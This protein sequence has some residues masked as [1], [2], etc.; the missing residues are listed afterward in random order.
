MRVSSTASKP[1]ASP[2]LPYLNGGAWATSQRGHD[3]RLSPATLVLHSKGSEMTSRRLKIMHHQ[4][5]LVSYV[6]NWRLRMN[7]MNQILNVQPPV[8]I[9]QALV[10]LGDNTR[11]L[12]VMLS[13]LDGKLTILEE[14]P[15]IAGQEIDYQAYSDA[16]TFLKMCYLLVRILF[17][18]VAGIIKYFYDENEPNSG[19]TISFN[20]LLRNAEKGRLPK[21]L[22]T[23]L[24]RTIVQF[25]IMRGR[26]D[27][28]E[29]Y[30]ESLLISFGQ[31]ED[32]KTTVGHFSTKRRTAKQ[33]E[34]IRQS[35]GSIL[36]EYQNLIDNILD[37]FDTKFMDWYRFKPPRASKIYAEGYAGIMLWWAY[38]YGNYRPKDLVVIEDS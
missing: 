11:D 29:H 13:Y 38:K 24:R 34:D 26:R 23:L 1:L 33:Y 20:D 19:A 18:D 28:L 22:S 27:D 21:D 9:P 14:T 30:Y 12:S 2:L 37:H 7:Q 35:F 25:P 31:D 16:R 8:D 3:Q 6:G 5:D 17:N 36:C 10:S 4:S 32:G 15:L